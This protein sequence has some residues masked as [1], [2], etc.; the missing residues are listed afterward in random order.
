[1]VV[2][3]NYFRI[4]WREIRGSVSRFFAIFCITALGVGFLAGLLSTTPDMRVSADAYYDKSRLMDIRLLSTM[5][6]CLEDVEAVAE[7]EGIRLAEGG[8]SADLLVQLENGDTVA[9]RV[10]GVD[11][12][13]QQEKSGLNQLEL[14]QGRFPENAGECLVLLEKVP[15]E[16]TEIGKALVFSADNPDLEDTV[17][18]TDMTVTGI[19]SCSYYMSLEREQASIG[20]GKLSMILFVPI[21]QFSFDYYTEIYASVEG[22]EAFQAFTDRYQ[23]SVDLVVDRLEEL[24]ETQPSVRRA[25]IIGQAQEELQSARDEFESQKAEA[26]QELED[27]WQEIL[28]GRAEIAAGERDLSRARTQ[29]RDGRT[30]L[31]QQRISGKA[32]LDES[33]A[34]LEAGEKEYADGLARY[35]EGKADLDAAKLAL[36]EAKPQIDQIRVLVTAGLPVNEEM[37]AALDQYDAGV[38]QYEAGAAELEA[39]YTQLTQ[40]RAQLDEGHEQLKAGRAA[41]ET[42]IADAEAQ[43]AQAERD[44]ASGSQTLE[45]AKIK[46]ADGEREYEAGKAEADEKLLD[47]EYQIR[48]AEAEIAK[49]E[50]PKW[51]VLSRRE[52]VAYVSFE[53]NAE[54][55]AAIARVFP[56]FFFLVAMLVTL[57]TMTRM[58]EEERTQIGTL[59]ALGYSAG[60]ITLKYVLYAGLASLLGSAVGL[61][62]GL[63]LFPS[64]IWKAYGI[65]YTL[66]PL[67]YRLNP[68][69]ALVSAFAL[70]VCAQAATL[71]A[72]MSS[73]RE[74]P[75]LLMRPKAPKA[76]K[77]IFLERLPFIWRRLK[78]THKV[79]ARNLFRYKKRF[80]M[81]VLGVAGCTALLLTGL[82]L[83]DSINAIVGKQFGELWNYNVIVAMRHDSD[84]LNDFRVGSLLSGDDFERTLAVHMEAGHAS[85]SRYRGETTLFVPRE[86][87][88]LPDFITLREREGH[89]PVLFE[90]QDAVI[91]TEKLSSRLGVKPGD[92]IE[93][94]DSDGK[95]A[96]VTVTGVVENYVQSYVYLTA[97]GYRAAFDKTPEYTSVL[98]VTTAEAEEERDALATRLLAENNIAGVQFND[99]VR[100]SFIDML[101]SINTIVVIIILS[102]GVLALVVLYNLTNIN[103]AEREKELATIKV[104]GFY[105]QEVAGYIFRET[106]LLAFVGMLC[107]LWLGIYLHAFVVQTAEVDMVMFGREISPIS[108]ILSAVLTMVF[109]LLVNLVMHRTLRRISMVESLK[110]PE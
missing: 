78:F 20:N 9:A 42:G 8:K 60:A 83:R 101:Q 80:F 63:Q 33:A 19:A 47:A 44:I 71:M 59:K 76:G 81:T 51:Y 22:A 91:I 12:Q 56:F 5:G 73:L 88:R 26:E 61:A 40:S 50:T 102:A 39:A 49:I 34:Q 13:A 74:Q 23:D 97:E 4:I 6:F 2:K 98:A 53:S 64:V 100:D 84:D 28:D 86:Q 36:D 15:L 79:T 105:R 17:S 106:N 25:Q 58:V 1:M 87:D 43:L 68:Q 85:N 24:A 52:N 29:F 82:G 45:E 57:T 72:C 99:T 110:A 89:A 69:Y 27:A 109:A 65:M 32:Q 70:I 3:K 21:E 55:V 14:L 46:L 94:E 18:R 54:K 48:D 38:A 77:R 95:R 107:G 93:L 92:T 104:L 16:G 96:A 66:P 41:Y 37:Q 35:N 31:Q 30:A 108:F 103:I 67:I 62:I 11:M 7:T 90:G 75:A 10:H